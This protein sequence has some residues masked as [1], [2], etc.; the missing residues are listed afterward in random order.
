MNPAWGPYGIMHAWA[1]VDQ[2]SGLLI[3]WADPGPARAGPSWESTGLAI[4]QTNPIVPR[5]ARTNPAW[6][7]A[8]LAIW[9]RINI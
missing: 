6:D 5:V 9:V 4:A 7:Q 8:G 2:V 3:P 1:N